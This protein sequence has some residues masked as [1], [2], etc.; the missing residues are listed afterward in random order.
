MNESMKNRRKVVFFLFLLLVI[1]NA[2]QM[3]M[4]PVIGMIEKEFKVT[5]SHI[6]LV[7]GVFSIVG[8][9]VS[10]VWGYLSDRYNRKALLVASILVGEIPCLLSAISG[11]F[12]QL[13]FWRVLTGIGIGA[14]FPISYSL[15]GDMFGHKERGKVVSILGLAST[16]GGIVG[17]LVAGYSA[18]IFGWRIPFILVS[19][20][21]LII[22]P[23]IINYL[24]EPKRGSHEEGFVE[25]SAEYV[26]NVKL[27]DYAQLVRVKTNLLLFLQGIA[28]TVPWGAIPY[29]MIEFFRREKMMDL[30]QATTMFLLF[31]LGSIAG[32]II[33][34]FVGE[35]VYQKSKR[36]VP[37]LSAITT[38]LGVFFTV[39]VFRYPYFPTGLGAFLTFGLLGFIAAA[40]DSYTGPNVKMMLLNV[41][42]PKD[43]GRIFSIFNLTDSVGTGIGRFFGGSMS[44]ALGTLGAAL[45]VSA[46]FWFICGFLLMLSA[47]YFDKEVEVLND[48]MRKLAAEASG[49]VR[50]L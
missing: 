20:P 38:I 15:V 39:L 27:S 22:I 45:E 25:S 28:G 50:R 42:E 7:G 35:K 5:D 33:G 43:R 16:V 34:G 24:E 23:L 41:N 1:L 6:G 26:A 13:F 9:L 4:S 3:V 48:K 8:A 17:M 11:T 21:N 30:N 12:G 36:L 37:L 47:W 19:A 31:A 29:F 2:D 10:L 18:G 14:S 44:V 32:N 40:M 46:Y 49:E